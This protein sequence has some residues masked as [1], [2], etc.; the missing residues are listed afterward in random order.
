MHAH[1]LVGDRNHGPT[2]KEQVMPTLNE[3]SRCQHAELV[4]ER[5]G[6]PTKQGPDLGR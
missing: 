2:L 6:W 3:S 1:K 5:G 4:R